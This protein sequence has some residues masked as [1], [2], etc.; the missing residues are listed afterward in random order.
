MLGITD[1]KTL[2]ESGV[3]VEDS[4]NLSRDEAMEILAEH[5][6]F[7]RGGGAIE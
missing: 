4:A 2:V 7:G 1:M 6:R 3:K 5:T